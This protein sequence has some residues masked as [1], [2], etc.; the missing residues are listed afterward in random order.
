MEP[1]TAQTVSSTTEAIATTTLSVPSST[2]PEFELRINCAGPE[3][4]DSNDKFGSPMMPTS[5]LAI[6]I[7]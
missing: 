7:P 5:I 2:M 4:V 3:Y 6:H 1:T